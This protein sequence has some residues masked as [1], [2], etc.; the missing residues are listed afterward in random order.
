MVTAT[1]I[2]VCLFVCFFFLKS[3]VGRLG[4]LH[5]TIPG[6]GNIVLRQPPTVALPPI[7]Q[8]KK[9]ICLIKEK[10]SLIRL[11]TFDA[12]KFKKVNYKVGLSLV[13]F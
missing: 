5:I 8:V 10:S 6:L 7:T 4:G 13:Y 9:F 2:I 3:M 11:E 1:Y 12:I